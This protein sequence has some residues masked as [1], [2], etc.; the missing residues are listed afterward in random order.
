MSGLRST[1]MDQNANQIIHNLRLLA[2]TFDVL[3]LHFDMLQG[4]REQIDLARELKVI[5]DFGAFA[6]MEYV[7]EPLEV[8]DEVIWQR[9]NRDLL[10]RVDMTS[11]GF[12]AVLVV[13]H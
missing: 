11:T 6:S 2:R 12:A 3:I 8:E 1:G 5:V 10:Y 13:Y 9:F 4:V 7:F